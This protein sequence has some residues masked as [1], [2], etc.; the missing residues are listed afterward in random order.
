MSLS[1][2]T[3]HE[4]TQ[5]SCLGHLKPP[6]TLT[7]TGLQATLWHL[8]LCTAERGVLGISRPLCTPGSLLATPVSRGGALGRYGWQAI[9]CHK[10]W[11]SRLA[12]SKQ[13]PRMLTVLQCVG[14]S[15]IMKNCPTQNASV[16]FLEKHC[17]CLGCLVL[18]D[19][20]T[21]RRTDGGS[22]SGNKKMLLVVTKN[23]ALAWKSNLPCHVS[24]EPHW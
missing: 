5:R 24:A 3:N 6:V 9:N 2:S 14:L 17:Y 20:D 21:A 22:G 13:G 23:P 16:T 1:L 11:G 7:L 4:Q 8:L 15:C 10:D 12:F 18:L 19:A